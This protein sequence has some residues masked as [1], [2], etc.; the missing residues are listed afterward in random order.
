M[1]DHVTAGW[2][3]DPTNT[4]IYRFWDGTTWTPQVSSAGVSALD[5]NPVDVAVASIPPAPGTA[6][7][8]TEPAQPTIQVN[9]RSSPG[10]GIVITMVLI[11]AVI[12]LVVVLNSGSGE[13]PGGA[14]NPPATSQTPTSSSS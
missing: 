7:P 2:S 9:Q 14:T 1:N 3:K 13:S 4:Y 12:V 5:P 8:T 10:L 6:A 11:V